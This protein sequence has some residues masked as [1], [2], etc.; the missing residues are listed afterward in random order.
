MIKADDLGNLI[1]INLK[2]DKYS[3]TVINIYGPNRD[4]PDFYESI[5][6]LVQERQAQ[7]DFVII[8]G[9]FNMVMD[10]DK[11]T[12]NYCRE[13]NVNAKQSLQKTMRESDLVDIWREMNQD[14]IQFTWFSGRLDKMARLDMFIISRP[15]TPLIRKCEISNSFRSDHAIISIVIDS[16][17]ERKGNGLWKFN[18]SLLKDE[19]YIRKVK[20]VI[21][22]TVRQY[23]VPL[24]E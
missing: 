22:Q 10:Q 8:C 3:L 19:D 7:G 4:S 17:Q 14:K 13:H 2:L 21:A 24:Y 11:D 23:V 1:A 12:L 20:N 5:Q 16:C 6:M 15:M 9:D 18:T